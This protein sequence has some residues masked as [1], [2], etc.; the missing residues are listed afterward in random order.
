M[1]SAAPNDPVWAKCLE[2][3]IARTFDSAS[4]NQGLRLSPRVGHFAAAGHAARRLA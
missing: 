4:S 2:L 1:N 3:R